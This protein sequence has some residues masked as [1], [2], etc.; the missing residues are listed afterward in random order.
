MASGLH[1]DQFA[2]RKF[3]WYREITLFQILDVKR[4][5][6]LHSFDSFFT[7]FAVG[8]ATGQGKHFRDPVAILVG[9]KQNVSHV[10]CFLLLTPSAC[11]SRWR[12]V[13]LRR[14]ITGVRCR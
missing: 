13:R 4:D 7:S 11:I 14:A 10:S 2:I 5:C 6:F 3:G 8:V 12:S 1:A 9:V